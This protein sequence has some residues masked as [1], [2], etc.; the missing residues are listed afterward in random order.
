MKKTMKSYMNTSLVYAF[1]AMIGGSASVKLQ[2]LPD[3]PA[4]RC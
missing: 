1:L 2:G 4:R 3:L